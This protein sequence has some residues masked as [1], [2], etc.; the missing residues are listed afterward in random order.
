VFAVSLDRGIADAHN[1]SDLN[2]AHGSY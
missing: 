1:G 2:K